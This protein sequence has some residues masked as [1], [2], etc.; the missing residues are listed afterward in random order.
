MPKKPAHPYT[1]RLAFE[2]LLLL[3]ATL[4]K[5]PGIG[6]PDFLDSS[7]NE[8]HNAISSV[9]VYLQQLA[10]EL[11]IELP[12]GYPAISTLRKD[13]ETL[14]RYAIL[15]QR[16]YRWGYYLGTGALSTTELKVAFNAIASQAQYQG[17]AQVRR[18][19]EILSKRLR[20]LDMELKGEFFYPT[21]QHL[22]RAIIHTDPEEMVTK[23]E[24]R[25]TLFHQLPLVEKAISKGEA[26][27]ISRSNDFYGFNRTGRIQVFPLQ[28]IYHDIAWYLLYEY[29]ENGHLAIGRLNRFNNHCKFLKMLPRGLEKQRENL[30]KAHKLLENGWGLNLGEPEPQKLELEG[31]LKFINAK[32]RFFPPISAFILEGERRHLYQKITSGLI[33]KTGQHT[34]IEYAVDLPPRSLNEFSL[35]VYRYMDKAEVLSPPQLVEQHR[36]STQ[37]LFDRY[38]H[39]NR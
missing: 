4:L 13:L 11:D 33:D 14:R 34:Y 22:N 15:D 26:I 2:R 8:S 6:S 23:G 3:I 37:A 38:F 5:Y 1:E 12:A 25:D 35:W 10:T 28:L 32:V 39:T 27:E 24:N 17:D 9:K 31:T 20:G 7:N 21:R 18:I 36:Q 19:Y 29:C 16:M 30:A